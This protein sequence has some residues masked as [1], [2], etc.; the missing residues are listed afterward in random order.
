[1][2]KIVNLR[3]DG[4]LEP[5]GITHYPPELSWRVD[6]SAGDEP[7][8][9]IR[10]A[11]APS[12][13][14]WQ[15]GRFSFE[16]GLPPAARRLTCP[17][18]LVS[19]E[20]VV[21]RVGVVVS[22]APEPQ[23]SDFARFESGLADNSDWRGCWVDFPAAWP[24]RSRLFQIIF[25]PPPR[26]NCA[27]LYLAS[28]G[29]IYPRLNGRSFDEAVLDPAPAGHD[30][31]VFYRAFDPGPFIVDGENML[32]VEAGNGWFG[33]TR[34]LW[35]L[36]F[37]G[38]PA[39]V[40]APCA[41]GAILPGAAVR[42]SIY[43]GEEYDGRL[44]YPATAYLPGGTIRQ[45]NNLFSRVAAPAGK[46]VA[47]T[48]APARRLGELPVQRWTRHG[49]ALIAD[50]GTN[51]AGWCRLR[52]TAPRGCRIEMRFAELL[53]PD[54]SLNQ[55]NLLVAAATDVYI[56][57][58]DAEGE[59][60]E[61]QFTWHGFRYVELRGYPG[62]PD[63]DT[64]TGIMV[65]GD[66]PATS[67]FSSSQPLLGEIHAMVE[68]TEAANLLGI[69]SD[70]PQRSERHGWLNDL[71]ARDETMF[72]FHDTGNLAE[73]WLDDIGDAQ[74]GSG[75]LPMTAPERWDFPG[76][77]VV[78]SSFIEVALQLYRFHGRLGALQRHYSGFRR[79]LDF[80]ASHAEGGILYG[81]AIGD[82]APP[83]NCLGPEGCCNRTVPA[84]LVSTALWYQAVEQT[85]RIAAI[86]GRESDEAELA[87]E[88][89]AIRLRFNAEFVSADGVCAG[90][91]QA[92]MV[93]PLR[94][95]L[96]P[97]A[98]R[99]RVAARL[100]DRVIADGRRL[101]TGNIGTAYLLEVLSG[102]G[103]L[104][105]AL[106]LALRREYPSW[107]YMLDRGATTLWER[108]EESTGYGMNSHSHPMLGSVGAW[109]F[110]DLGGVAPEADACG[111]DLVRL[112]PAFPAE[113]VHLGLGLETERGRIVS[114]WRRNGREIDW[115]LELPC[116]CSGRIGLPAGV[117][118]VAGGA[119]V[120]EGPAVVDCRLEVDDAN[121]MG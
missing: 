76:V 15:A 49:E 116:G 55:E 119:Q 83:V 58:G 112:R 75:R 110:R 59:C 64:L 16:I 31:R 68:R 120:I 11:A 52:V 86:L 97:E 92:S 65:G 117:N 61:P 37:D 93:Y 29:Y 53:H 113:L 42:Q 20:R 7:I 40:S 46:L 19:R 115:H 82:W 77:E 95:G 66:C 18:Q 38:V 73:K 80:L 69:P 78:G 106:E 47:Q 44:E 3:C 45:L 111:F 87:A 2:I 6:A 54:G 48:L 12:E 90:D 4:A 67:E 60:F 10:V 81:G 105:L 74:D 100:A 8:L 98:L 50:F 1:M 23:W 34:V 63:E 103:R 26:W 101:N 56:C 85:R 94:V 25:T 91:S 121:V 32:T 35:Q 62:M 104:E 108:W 72:Y 107:G 14:A 36:E 24:G 27:R 22:S 109:L 102:S 41:D 114:R 39:V 99:D 21:W 70:C 89:A 30:R 71:L 57:R 43:D 118:R 9:A 5:L 28:P 79:W 96:I 84:E 13:E 51:F 17:L 88:A 33:A